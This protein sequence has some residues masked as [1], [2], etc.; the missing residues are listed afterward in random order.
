MFRRSTLHVFVTLIA[1][2]THARALDLVLLDNTS[3]LSTSNLSTSS[4]T[5][6]GSNSPAY[7]RINGYTFQV[8]ATSYD[9]SAVTIPIR[10]GG[11]GSVSPNMRIEVWELP[12]LSATM[13]AGSAAPFYTMD[14]ASNTFDSTFQYFNFP[15]TNGTLNL[16]ANTRYAIGFLSDLNSGLLQWNGFNPAGST[17]SGSYGLTSISGS[18]GFYSTNGGSSYSIT[19]MNYGFQ[20]TGVAV[21]EPSTY[22]FAALSA[23][24]LVF[25]G[26]CWRKRSA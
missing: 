20:L 16:K 3:G 18:S 17:P 8:G 22:A 15:F 13:P 1:F 2:C 5:T 26:R 25:S 19:T 14:V 12:N 23:L 10:W 7:N 21:P 6:W 9:A 24:G 4:Q 11:G